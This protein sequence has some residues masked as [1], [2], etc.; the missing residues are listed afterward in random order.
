MITVGKGESMMSQRI[1]RVSRRWWSTLVATVTLCLV[2]GSAWA[3][4]GEPEAATALR[5]EWILA[6]EQ[7]S[8]RVDRAGRLPRRGPARV[9]GQA[10]NVLVQ[11][12]VRDRDWLQRVRD[13]IREVGLYG[14]SLRG[15]VGGYSLPYAD[16]MVNLLVVTNQT[17]R[18]ETA[19]DRSRSGS[20]G[21][22]LD[23]TGWPVNVVSQG[24]P[25]D[26]DQWSHTRYDATGN[27]VSKDK[28]VGPPRYL[29]WE[30]SPRWNRGV[31][32][33]S[34]VTT[35]GRIFYILDDSH[36]AVRH[37]HLVTDRTRRL[38]WH[39]ALAAG[40]A[41]LGW[42]SRWQKSR[43]SSGEPATGGQRRARVCH[44]G[45]VG[46]GQHVGCG[47][48]RVDPHAQTVRA[49][50]RVHLVGRNIWWCW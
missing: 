13:Q 9:V 49:G 32:T 3:Q 27:A 8:G 10:P 25:D 35:Q 43:P 23:S 24:W 20:I 41:Q 1:T 34:L 33:S 50:R 42:G 31:K 47:D 15:A 40:I 36:F 26:V 16:G 37:T 6:R 28:R 14:R 11:G 44:P 46:P 38:Q 17:R 2:V 22:R 48:R 12:L 45:R 39:P 19:R 5:G 7:V 30:A 29:Q 18:V 4:Q 21:R